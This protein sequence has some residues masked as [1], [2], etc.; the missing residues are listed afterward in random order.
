M[1]EKSSL[2]V[3]HLELQQQ[4]KQLI[5]DN[6]F[7]NNRVRSLMEENKIMNELKDDNS[8]INKKST[9]NIFKGNKIR[10]EMCKMNSKSSNSLLGLENN[11]DYYI[12]SR[13]QK[14]QKRFSQPSDNQSSARM[15]PK[16]TIKQ[17]D[18]SANDEEIRVPSSRN[19][20]SDKDLENHSVKQ[21]SNHKISR[22]LPRSRLYQLSV[23]MFDKEAQMIDLNEI[24]E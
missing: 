5:Q 11:N 3:L 12:N 4:H 8:Q 20:V 15:S 24:L 1:S 14:F 19:S 21:K 9:N 22:S 17:R 18:S 10:N 6:E 7:L 2:Q 16:I 13:E 23:G